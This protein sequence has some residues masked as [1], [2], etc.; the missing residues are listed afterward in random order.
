MHSRN[1]QTIKIPFNNGIVT[2][3]TYNNLLAAISNDDKIYV[4]ELGRFIDKIP[5]NM[6][7]SQ[8]KRS[9]PHQI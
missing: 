7:L 4:L 5:E 6:R 2:L 3:L 1:V 9:L 8:A